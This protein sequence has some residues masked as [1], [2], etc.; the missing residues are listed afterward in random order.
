MKVGK[1]TANQR[2]FNAK[3]NER[4]IDLIA[5]DALTVKDYRR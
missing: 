2:R 1:N 3:K 4:A 5:T